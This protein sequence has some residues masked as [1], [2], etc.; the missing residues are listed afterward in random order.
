MHI[1]V[2]ESGRRI[3]GKPVKRY[4]SV[5]YEHGREFRETFDA[6]ELAQEKLDKVKSLLAQGQSA[7][8]LRERGKET[9]EV[10]AAQWLASRHDLKPRTR[11]EYANLLSGKTR[12]RKTGEGDST[13][14]LSISATFNRREVNTITRS[15][16]ADWIGKLSSAGKSASTVRHH[17]F[18]VR[19]VFSE[20]VA[21]G[22]LTVNPAD[23]VKLPTERSAAGGTP[24]VVDNP[25]MFLTAVQVSALVA[26]TPWPCAVLVHV[27]AW[28]GLRAAELAGLQVGDVELPDQPI[29]PNAV[30][31]P[32]VLRVERTIITIDGKLVYDSPKAKGSR[33]RVPMMSATT[34]LLRDY[35][36]NHP[37]RDE[38]TAP[39]FCSVMLKPSKPTGKRAVDSDGSRIAP[40]ADEALAAL[41][42]PEAA[43]RL[44]LDWTE[45]I[46]HQTFYKAVFR[47]AVSRANRLGGSDP[48]LP[49]A[50]K[51]HALRHTYASLCVAAG[52]PPLQLSRFMGH[53]KVTTTLS[54]YTDLFDDDHAET[55][56][57][58]EATSRPAGGANVLPMRQRS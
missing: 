39:L 27:A 46:R 51:F 35:L 47:P 55:M 45:P 58:L 22:R 23:H 32:G 19:Q 10:V 56:A 54:I 14:D 2:R 31:K 21:D 42:V 36:K 43:D 41:S 25:D 13:E 40:T 49:P 17:Y 44:V 7:A 24:G 57:A 12:A 33:R 26:A 11:A 29:N 18:V 4:Q 53:A 20:C 52:I 5:W 1:R 3:N 8:S 15:D 34:E 50:L 30:A 38:P 28:C 6:R 16:I 37:R 48:V 9:F